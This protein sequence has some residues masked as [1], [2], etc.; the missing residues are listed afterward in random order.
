MTDC[1]NTVGRLSVTVGPPKPSGPHHPHSHTPLLIGEWGVCGGTVRS[2]GLHSKP[3]SVV[4][5]DC[6]RNCG[7]TTPKC[8]RIGRVWRSSVKRCRAGKLHIS[9]KGMSG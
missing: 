8:T 5:T 1:G 4:G 7:V 9:A 6:R 2:V 3:L